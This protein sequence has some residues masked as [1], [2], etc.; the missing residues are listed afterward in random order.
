MKIL[1]V[2][3]QYFGANN[4]MTISARR[5]SSVL[6]AHGHEVRIVSTTENKNDESV[7]TYSLPRLKIPIFDGLVTSQGMQFA[8]PVKST[9]EPAIKWADVV[10]FLLPFALTHR[11]IQ[12]CQAMNKPYTAAFHVQPENITSSIHLGSSALVNRCVYDWFNFYIYRHCPHVHC[13]SRFIASQLE[14]H[15]YHSQLHVISN[16]IDPDF[17]YQKL[18][19]EPG[20]E[21][22]FVILSIGRLSVEKRQNILIEAVRRSRHETEIQLLLAGQGPRRSAL[23]AQGKTLTH[24]PIIQFYSKPEL[25]RRI[26]QADLYVHAACAEIEAMSC[27]EAFAGGLVPII[28]DSP[29]SATPQFALDERSLFPVDDPQALAEK[30]DYWIEHPEQR[31]QMEHAYSASAEHYRLDACVRQAEDMF[32]LA[33]KEQGRRPA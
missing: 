32:R 9:L 28:A 13:P 3:D 1:M 14:Q 4:G 22:R 24:P 29:K 19:K 21:G 20:L 25:L 15:G 10:H 16:G 26:A 17:H 31:R 7:Y 5:F 23:E 33:M 11:G 2:I 6:Q 18:P 27:M 8:K 30:I 12:L